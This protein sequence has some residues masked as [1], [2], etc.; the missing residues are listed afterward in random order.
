M[1]QS[2][3]ALHN[4]RGQPLKV[5]PILRA[6]LLAGPS[7][8]HLSA[9]VELHDVYPA[10]GSPVVIA[11]NTMIVRKLPQ[12]VDALIGRRPVANQVSEAP[13]LIYGLQVHIGQDRIKS[14]NV[15][16]YVGN[17]QVAHNSAILPHCAGFSQACHEVV[18]EHF[19]KR[20][21]DCR[22]RCTRGCW[23]PAGS[24]HPG[25]GM[26]FSSTRCEGRTAVVSL[27]HSGE[28]R[29]NRNPRS[30]LE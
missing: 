19:S 30:H 28:R 29:I 16:V 8:G 20:V 2:T 17:N 12:A 24:S 25:T 26:N 6:Q 18:E 11:G 10:N 22:S 13:Y 14:D 15:A 1:H 7:T 9:G 4:P 5:V 21:R 27:A 23:S 3:I